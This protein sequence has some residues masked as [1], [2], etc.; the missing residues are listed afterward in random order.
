[1]YGVDGINDKSRQAA[2]DSKPKTAFMSFQENCFEIPGTEE[3]F[4]IYNTNEI[5]HEIR[6]TTYSVTHRQGRYPK[7]IPPL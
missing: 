3:S 6:P 5:N 7:A 1:M 4:N 2:P